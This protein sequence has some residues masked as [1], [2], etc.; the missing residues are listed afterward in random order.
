MKMSPFFVQLGRILAGYAAAS[1][2]MIAFYL[3][4]F[5]TIDEASNYKEQIIRASLIYTFTY[6][7]VVFVLPLL[8]VVSEWQCWRRWLA[9]VSA[10]VAAGVLMLALMPTYY[11]LTLAIGCAP[12]GLT[13]W[14]IAGRHAGKWRANAAAP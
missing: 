14:A 10:D 9:F 12:T 1:A 6:V 8:I 3:L 11:L 2:V 4:E 7:I 5:S 13:Y